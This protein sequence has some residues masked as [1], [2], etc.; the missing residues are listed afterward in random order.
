MND[1]M[2]MGFI[3]ELDKIADAGHI[4][5]LAGLGILAAPSVKNLADPKASKKEKSHAKFE[6][7][8]LGVLAAPAAYKLLTKKAAPVSAA[9]MK[10]MQQHM[11][12]DAHKALSGG[13]AKPAPALRGQSQ[14]FSA[15]Q[16]G[17]SAHD[18]P[19]ELARPA[20]ATPR[21]MAARPTAVSAGQAARAGGVMGRIGKFFKGV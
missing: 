19:L 18:A 11:R 1:S 15:G 14:T 9:D 12:S 2:M 17:G 8:G 16:L 4:A 5:E 7:A 13:G 20:K 10:M 3:D 21:P 6:T